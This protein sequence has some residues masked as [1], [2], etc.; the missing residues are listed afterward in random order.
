MTRLAP[1]LPSGDANGL[2][3]ISRRLINSPHAITAVVALVDC[4]RLLTDTDTGDVEPTARIRRIEPIVGED[5][6]LAQQILRRALE[7]RTGQTVLP[8]DLEEDLRTLG[9]QI[10]PDT[11]EVLGE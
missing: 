1:G 9:L 10:D 7:Q 6:Q 4:S 3:A 5:V 8:F 11:G 2:S